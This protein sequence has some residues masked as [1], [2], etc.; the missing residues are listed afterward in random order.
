[1]IVEFTKE[2]TNNLIVFLGRVSLNPSG[3]KDGTFREM[4]AMQEILA[5]LSLAQKKEF[6]SDKK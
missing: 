3:E 2:Q 6:D 4:G 5:I 1:M